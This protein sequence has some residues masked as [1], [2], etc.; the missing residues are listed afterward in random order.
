MRGHPS[1]TPFM[2]ERVQ[3]IRRKLMSSTEGTSFW[4]E[5]KNGCSRSF[6]GLA[7]IYIEKKATN[8]KDKELIDDDVHAVLLN[9]TLSQW[10]YL[11]ENGLIFTVFC[12]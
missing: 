1:Q 11:V 4:D 3:Q 6:V 9:F 7:K 10:W 2:Q 8:L 12:V 5:R